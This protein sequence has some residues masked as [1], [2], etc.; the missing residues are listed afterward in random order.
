MPF[1]ILRHKEC[2]GCADCYNI[3]YCAVCGRETSR[4]YPWLEFEKYCDECTE[5]MKN[6]E[7]ELT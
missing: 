3:G 7:E 6:Q 4:K 1:C 5:V 2:D